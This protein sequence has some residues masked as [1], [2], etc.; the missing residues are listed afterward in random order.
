VKPRR[1][2]VFPATHGEGT[3]DLPV[4]EVKG[5]PGASL[6]SLAMTSKTDE[7]AHLKLYGFRNRD[8]DSETPASDSRAPEGS[9]EVIVKDKAPL[10]PPQPIQADPSLL[11]TASGRRGDLYWFNRILASLIHYRASDGQ[12]GQTIVCGRLPGFSAT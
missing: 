6:H 5:L 8:G 3:V 9:A 1:T 4:S 11:S 12:D 10:W 7:F 2:Q